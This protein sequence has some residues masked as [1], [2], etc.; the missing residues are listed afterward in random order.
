MKKGSPEMKEK[1]ANK[2]FG[3]FLKGVGKV[4]KNPIV[5]QIG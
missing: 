2:G 1:M 5:K 4:I 3:S